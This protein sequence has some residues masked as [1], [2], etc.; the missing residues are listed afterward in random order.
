MIRGL[1]KEDVEHLDQAFVEQGWESLLSILQQY[2]IEIQ[3]KERL[4][5]ID[6]EEGQYRGYITLVF[7]PQHGPCALKYFPEIVDF[8]VFEKY[9]G[10]G[11]GCKLL[12]EMLFDGSDPTIDFAVPKAEQKIP[13]FPEPLSRII[14]RSPT[15]SDNLGGWT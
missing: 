2:L 8:N 4:V 9:Q 1:Q 12:S 6:V 3:N 7:H 14:R 11:V 10:Q 5:L 13:M 15:K